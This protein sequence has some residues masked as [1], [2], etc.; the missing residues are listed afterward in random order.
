MRFLL[1]LSFTVLLAVAGVENCMALTGKWRGDISMGAVKLPLVFNFNE[2]SDGTTE[3][4]MDSPQQNAKDIPLDVKFCSQDS[5]YLECKMIG[6]SYTGR[7]ESDKIE[8][9]FSQRGFNLPLTLTPEEDLSARRP[10]T[11]QPPFP[12]IEKDTVFVSYDGTE[13]AGTLTLPNTEAGKKFPTVVMVTGS[14]PQNRDEEIFEHKPFAVIADY[15]ARNGIASFRFDDRGTAL[16][17]GNYSEA[18]IDTFK[19]DA[20]SACNFVKGLPQTGKTGILGHSEGGTLAVLMAADEKPDFIVSLA[21]MVIPAKETLLDQNIHSLDQLGISG[22]QKDA[23]VELIEKLFDE[24]GRQ[25]K[26]GVTSP[27]DIELIC[28]ENSLEVPEIVLESIKRNNV[29]RNSYFDSMVSLDP[30][31]ALKK[32]KCPVLAINGT[33]DMQVNAD[34]NLEA[35]RNNV[36]NVDIQRM[37]GLNH[38]MQHATTGEVTEYNQIRE[39]ISPEVLTLISTFI[40]RQK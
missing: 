12:Y 22:K 15:L 3:A 11:P 6:A 35:F 18:T 39:T 27:I 36:K 30:T 23:C 33:K 7:I 26:S 17:K 24:I 25:Y 10:Q 21:G 5:I 14:G 16:S 20:R 1:G 28:R 40:S 34:K 29:T 13:L 4:T 19:E 38:L 8:G 9:T 31:P 37:E 2:T 32:V